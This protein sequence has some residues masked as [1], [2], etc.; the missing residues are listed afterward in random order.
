VDVPWE[1][2]WGRRALDAVNSRAELL[3]VD[4]TLERA[5]DPY[6][7]VRDAWIQR[8]EFVIFDGNPPPEVLEEEFEEDPAPETPEQ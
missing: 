2:E 4:A 1:A 8:R 5:Y 7:F 6:A 3:S